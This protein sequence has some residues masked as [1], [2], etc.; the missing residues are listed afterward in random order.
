MTAD[1]DTDELWFWY[2][3]SLDS[4]VQDQ[5]PSQQVHGLFDSESE[6][7]EH[8]EH[9]GDDYLNTTHLELYRATVTLEDIEQT[10]PGTEDRADLD[11][12]ADTIDQMNV[13]DQRTLQ[14]FVEGED[15]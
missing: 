15:Q 7:R 12:R 6:A 11:D 1:D 14:Q 8:L 2:N 13:L 9:T 10:Q 3:P 4:L 5:G